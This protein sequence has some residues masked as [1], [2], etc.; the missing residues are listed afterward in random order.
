[1][2]S[3]DWNSA[4]TRLRSAIGSLVLGTGF[5]L[6]L[7]WPG[8]AL[9]QLTFKVTGASSELRDSLKSASLLEQAHRAQDGTPREL[10]AAALADYGRLTEA[11][12]GEGYYGGVVQI[13]VDGREAADVPLF[14]V[15]KH[16]QRIDIQIDPGPLFRF[17]RAGV[18]PLAP[19][20]A[21][22]ENFRAGKVAR[23]GEVQIALDGAAEAWRD[24]GYAKVGLAAQ[25][26][27][28]N[29][30]T[31]K[32]TALLKLDPGPK[33][34]FGTLVQQSESG[35]RAA[36]I[37]RI[38]GLPTGDVFSPAILRKVATRLRRT[39]AFASVSLSEG[40]VLRAGNVMD[41]GLSLVDE[42][43][44]RFGAGAEL[45]T[46]DGLTLTGF[47]M[48]RNLLG[49]A[50]R[51]RVDGEVSGIGSV[52]GGLDYRL[53]ARLDQPATFGADTNGYLL[54]T[55]S[56]EDEPGFISR[57]VELG[58]GAS[59]IFSDSLTGELG[60]GLSYAETTDFKGDRR[61]V[62]LTLPGALT[63]DRRDNELNPTE[64]FYLRADAK[65]FLSLEGEGAGLWALT[66]ARVFHALDTDARYVL[67]GRMQLGGV[68]AGATGHIPPDF[69]FYSGGGNSVRG[70]PYKSLGVTRNGKMTGGQGYLALSAEMRADVTDKIGVVGFFDA[71]HV[72]DDGF[73]QGKD[74][75]HS[76]AGLGLRYQTP[77][78][79]L[80][81]DLGVP[82]T[83]DTGNGLQLYLGIGQAF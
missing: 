65:P 30:A 78:G 9:D 22:P 35:V 24:A 81:L 20:H 37:Q 60:V 50:E 38:A 47:W 10:F 54:A 71:G 25:T 48:H 6:G 34:R 61:F 44:R 52:D 13:R 4:V 59:R 56:Y 58:A 51:F 45:S 42:R 23:S 7:A 49:G 21:L 28:A 31:R 36:R 18:S 1:M 46:L 29:H 33:V 62:L 12:Y 17:D 77:I 57:K 64:G 67:A 79:P 11:L 3:G 73:F 66:D 16:I 55:L 26:L 14:S 75:W 74:S 76:G 27:R 69:L 2:P 5:L 43:P 82:V 68:F 40:D 32:L 41:I 15:P 8:L 63:W 19:G 83:G 70:Q 53:G 39:G 80:R 72:G